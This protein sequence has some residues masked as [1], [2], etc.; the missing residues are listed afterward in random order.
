MA[1]G[2]FLV[3]V[4]TLETSLALDS[5]SSTCLGL[6]GAGIKAR[7]TSS[8]PELLALVLILASDL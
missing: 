7:V 2:V 5:Q 3:F 8:H 1:L 6:P 4:F